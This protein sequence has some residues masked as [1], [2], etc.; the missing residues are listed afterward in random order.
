M[1]KKIVVSGINIISGGALT[2]L[3]EFL[4]LLKQKKNFKIILLLNSKK[5]I[6]NRKEF[7]ILEF[8]MS[9]KNYFFRTQINLA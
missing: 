3:E 4:S 6:K 9:K 1:E 7:E 2:V 8:P 5:I